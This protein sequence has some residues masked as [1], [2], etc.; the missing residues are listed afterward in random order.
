[1]PNQ[2]TKAKCQLNLKSFRFKPRARRNEKRSVEC[3]APSFCRCNAGSGSAF[4][5][6]GAF[7]VIAAALLDPF[8]AAIAIVG[9]VRPV[10]VEAG[11]SARLAGRIL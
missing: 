4:E 9:L 11:L 8:Q 6:L 10:L 3:H 1:M 5:L 7:A 2:Q